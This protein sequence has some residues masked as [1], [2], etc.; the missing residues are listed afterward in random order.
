MSVRLCR[1]CVVGE[2]WRKRAKRIPWL[3]GMEGR[4][5]GWGAEPSVW[6]KARKVRPCTC[7]HYNKR[8]RITRNNFTLYNLLS[9]VQEIRQNMKHWR[10]GTL[11][12][13]VMMFFSVQIFNYRDFLMFKHMFTRRVDSDCLYFFFFFKFAVIWKCSGSPILVWRREDWYRFPSCS[14]KAVTDVVQNTNTE[15]F[16]EAGNAA[17]YL[18]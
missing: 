3:S 6:H 16:A 10:K 1:C 9:S 15:A 11:T 5:Q 8:V 13:T 14:F 12:S 18:P 2:L 17:S 4:R 7:P